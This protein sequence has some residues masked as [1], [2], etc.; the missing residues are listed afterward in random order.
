MLHAMTILHSSSFTGARRSVASAREICVAPV[1]NSCPSSINDIQARLL[2]CRAMVAESVAVLL[3]HP[4]MDF[5][6]PLG[7][8]FAMPPARTRTAW[9]ARQGSSWLKV[10]TRAALAAAYSRKR[11]ASAGVF[12]IAPWQGAKIHT[13]GGLEP[14]GT[15]QITI[16]LPKN[17]PADGTCPM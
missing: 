9:P 2:P 17:C 10:A 14:W 5:S 8:C 16:R 4:Y 1:F 6:H 12:K 3:G 11:A 13:L 7:W 15:P